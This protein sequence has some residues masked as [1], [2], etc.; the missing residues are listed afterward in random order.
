[1]FLWFLSFFRSKTTSF[2]LIS[3]FVPLTIFSTLLASYPTRPAA[4]EP[5][6]SSRANYPPLSTHPSSETNYSFYTHKTPLARPHTWL[7]PSDCT[8]VFSTCQ[9]IYYTSVP[10]PSAV[11]AELYRVSLHPYHSPHHHPFVSSIDSWWSLQPPQAPLHC[12]RPSSSHAAWL[13]A[14]CALIRY[15]QPPL[16]QVSGLP[17]LNASGL[18]LWGT[19]RWVAERSRCE[20]SS[21]CR[22]VNTLVHS[23]RALR[24]LGL[25]NGNP[26]GGNWGQ[27][28]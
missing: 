20:I 15:S 2:K 5:V 19:H 23:P 16:V 9:C 14:V 6:P 7:L 24:E 26:E 27:S 8:T 28:F 11:S 10:I 22:E 18:C 13:A 3:V 25:E 17:H 21:A 12:L 1:M 4:S